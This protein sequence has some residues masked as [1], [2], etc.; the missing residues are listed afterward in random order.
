MNILQIILII[1]LFTSLLWVVCHVRNHYVRE[2]E[3]IKK[4]GTSEPHKRNS[5]LS[6][7]TVFV[8]VV[9]LCS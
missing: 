2:R 8:I 9:I 3:I 5:W 1:A 7:V 4:T 6:V